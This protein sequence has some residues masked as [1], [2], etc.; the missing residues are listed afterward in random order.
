MILVLQS[1]SNNIQV[2]KKN[3]KWSVWNDKITIDDHR[4]VLFNTKMRNAVLIENSEIICPEQLRETDVE[5]LY[6]NGFLVDADLDEKESWGKEFGKGRDEMSFIDLTILLTENCQM[7]C[8]YCFEGTKV[9]KDINES[10]IDDILS[11]LRRYVN[12][13]TRLR[14]TWF[15]GEPLMAYPQLRSMTLKLLDFCDENNI[16]YSADITTNGFALNPERCWEIVA[17]LKVKRFII[18]LDGPERIH[19]MRRPLASHKPTYKIIM[20]NI[21]ALVELGAWVTVRMTID[22]RNVEYIPEFL[23][24]MAMDSLK[25]R[26]GLAYCRTID[27]NFT[28]ERIKNDIYTASEFVDVEWNLIQYAHKLGLWKYH[29]PHSA[30]LGGCLRKGDIVIGTDG[31]IYKCLDTL[32]DTKWMSGHIKNFGNN[33]NDIPDWMEKW[34]N[35][36]PFKSQKCKNCTLIPLCNGGCPH[37]ALFDDKKHGSDTGCPDWKGNYKRQ[38]KSLIIEEYENI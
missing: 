28:P 33:C 9:R 19:E 34:S 20:R 21:H 11:F 10:T 2:G 23:D 29:F 5:M 38:I 6:R 8:Q 31:E 25:G 13:C 32:G 7:R 35:W 37:N 36:T 4:Y 30:P 12:V 1:T 22:K 26:V 24:S 14:V 3:L 16:E 27:Y 18:T 15:G 17:S